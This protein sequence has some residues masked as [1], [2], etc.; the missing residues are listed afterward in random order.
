MSESPILP[1]SADRRGFL[2]G[3]IGA[4]VAVAG[5]SLLTGCA[6][7]ATAQAAP[8]TSAPSNSWDMSWTS[9]LGRYRT[10]YDSPEIMSGAALA[11]AASAQSSVT[12]C[13]SVM[14][15]APRS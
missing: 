1:A 12:L 15:R 13:V 6:A 10:A 7:A 9:K 14:Y 5:T 11:F 3:L 4:G 8:G 2:T